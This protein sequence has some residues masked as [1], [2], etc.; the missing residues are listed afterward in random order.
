MAKVLEETDAPITQQR[1]AYHL[2]IAGY[3]VCAAVVSVYSE[4]LQAEQLDEQEK[5]T[6]E[7]RRRFQV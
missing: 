4:R 3:D 1:A 7:E 2:E 6:P 5:W